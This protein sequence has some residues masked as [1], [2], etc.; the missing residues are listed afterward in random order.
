MLPRDIKR[1]IVSFIACGGPEIISEKLKLSEK[2][3]MF[4][5]LNAETLSSTIVG[6]NLSIHMLR[7]SG[8]WSIMCFW[9]KEDSET[10]DFTFC[11]KI[12]ARLCNGVIPP[13]IDLAPRSVKKLPPLI[14]RSFE[15][16]SEGHMVSTQYF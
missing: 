9:S 8:A 5:V 10:G 12:T 2:R 14:V 7:E 6:F 4:D 15:E 11:V 13:L 3:I 16:R 1:C